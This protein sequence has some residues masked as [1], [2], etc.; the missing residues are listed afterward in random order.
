MNFL[1]AITKILCS[2]TEIHDPSFI[3][4]IQVI[5]TSAL[6]GAQPYNNA[7]IM[8]SEEGEG[9]LIT[10]KESN[11]Y[12]EWAFEYEIVLPSLKY[13][14]KAGIF[15]WYTN[16][17]PM[18]M[19][20]NE[21]DFIGLVIGLEMHG[22]DTEVLISSKTEDNDSELVLRDILSRKILEGVKNLLV[23]IIYTKKNFKIELYNEKKLLYD[24]LRFYD[25]KDLGIKSGKKFSITTNYD[26]VKYGEH[27]L[28]KN[29]SLLQRN[30]YDS[31]DPNKKMIDIENDVDHETE[32]A[33]ANLEH[34]MKYIDHI[35]GKPEG[36]TIV[37]GVVGGLKEVKN[38]K[39]KIESLKES[40]INL[41]I[42]IGELPKIINE[43]EI[44]V[45]GLIRKIN[46]LKFFLKNFD[47]SQRKSGNWLLIFI[48][49]CVIFGL[50]YN[51]KKETKKK[52]S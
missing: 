32:H 16:N 46:D 52:E 11:K 4:N 51:M 5:Q 13:P 10:F 28:L 43:T 24:C 21:N 9:S 36:S 37:Q 44:K 25:T 20:D 38:Q 45:Q 1:L 31:Y 34:L 23:K 42:N 12:D 26:N 49:F 29:V 7:L 6:R 3:S 14:E 19:A 40:V 2:Y 22:H 15:L 35:F 17:D 18:G 33:L 41:T 48:A 47:H 39:Q 30:E 8:R 27:F 50:I